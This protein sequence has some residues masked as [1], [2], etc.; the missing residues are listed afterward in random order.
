[1]TTSPTNAPGP[2]ALAAPVRQCFDFHGLAVDI[3]VE[4][5]RTA[6]S[7]WRDWKYFPRRQACPAEITIRLHREAPAFE[8]VPALDAALV[9][10]RNVCYRLDGIEY[11]DYFGRGLAIGNRA[12][13]TLEAWSDDPDLLR[14]IAYLFLL[15]RVG[16]H[17]DHRGRHRIHALG[18]NHQGRGVLLLLPVAG[19]KSTMALRLLQRDDITLLSEDTP[20]VDARGMLYPFPLRLGVR[21]GNEPAIP[22]EFMQTVRRMEFGP[23]TLI[24]LDYFGDRVSEPCPARAVLIGVRSSGIDSRIEAI[25]RRAALRDVVANLVVGI[26]V[27]QGLEFV[28]QRSWGELVYQARPALS[29]LHTGLQLLRRAR[30]YRFAL[31]RD[32]ERNCERLEQFLETELPR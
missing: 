3:E 25:P 24:D 17:V 32:R 8:R 19:G 14:E 28:L 22:P 20:L 27:Y 13:G 30:P 11:L 15:S 5:D 12:A 23:K 9:T 31:G 6:E 26:G 16:Q 2:A 1:M 21:P 18:V 4:D 10:P 7:V 29:R